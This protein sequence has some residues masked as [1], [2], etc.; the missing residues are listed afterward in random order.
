MDL[1]LKERLILAN[2][3]RILALLDESEADYHQRMEKV[4]KEGYALHYSHMTSSFEEDGLSEDEC[5]FVID[6]L[7]MHRALLRSFDALSPAEQGAVGHS[8]ESLTFDGFDGNNDD[9]FG[10]VDFLV[11][12]LGKW[13]EVLDGRPGWD[14]NSHGHVISIYRRMLEVWRDLPDKFKMT[15]EGIKCVVDARIHPENR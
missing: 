12:D 1:T 7:D 10:Y 2:Q 13:Q 3:Y 15:I 5:R 11:N 6:T 14:L 4:V 8:R 9:E